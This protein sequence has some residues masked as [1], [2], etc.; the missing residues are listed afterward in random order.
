[1]QSNGSKPVCENTGK[2]IKRTSTDDYAYARI[3]NTLTQ[4]PQ[5]SDVESPTE[6][7][8]VATPIT[9]LPK[10]TTESYVY[11]SAKTL[12]KDLFPFEFSGYS[13]IPTNAITPHSTPHSTAHST[14]HST[15]HSTA[16]STPHSTPFSTAHSTPFSTAHS[17]PF[18]TAHTTPHDTPF[19]TA[20]STAHV[21][22]FTTPFST[23]FVTVF[24][25][26][27]GTPFITNFATAASTPQTTAN[28]TPELTPSATPDPGNAIDSNPKSISK[29][30]VIVGV[31]IGCL[32][33]ILLVALLAFYLYK[34]SK[35]DVSESSHE[36]SQMS[37]ETDPGNVENEPTMTSLNIQQNPD[38]IISSSDEP[39][40]K[41]DNTLT[42]VFF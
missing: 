8:Y 36:I 6:Y 40:E 12:E 27:F 21:T 25:T 17:T 1:M 30:G 35:N 18:S 31:V 14:P 10:Q 20:H 22:P 28:T 26:P 5:T 3:S 29:T 7:T 33:F 42:D 2:A 13:V 41:E 34:R 32:I 23:A 24:E 11:P 37:E 38:E 9:R 16:H 4:D 19:S 39:Q 15:P